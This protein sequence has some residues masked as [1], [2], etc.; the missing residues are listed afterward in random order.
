VD[1]VRE[2]EA[3]DV[4]GQDQQVARRGA[5]GLH[6]LRGAP[7]AAPTRTHAAIVSLCTSSPQ[8]RFSCRSIPPSSATRWPPTGGASLVTTLLAVLRGNNAGFRTAPTSYWIANSR[9]QVTTVAF[10][11]RPHMGQGHDSG[12]CVRTPAG[13]SGGVVERDS[14]PSQHPPS[15]WIGKGGQIFVARFFQD[16]RAGDSEEAGLTLRAWRGRSGALVRG[17][18]RS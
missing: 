8:Q 14:I 3:S 6:M 7:G 18:L 4:V 9:Y 12:S 17:S 10:R 15:C 11:G 16:T 1:A 5:E 13:A 2:H